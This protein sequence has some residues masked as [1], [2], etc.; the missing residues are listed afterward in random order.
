MKN[1]TE[2]HTHTYTQSTFVNSEKRRN[3][4][5]KLYN[6]SREKEGVK[7]ARDERIRETYARAK[8][9]IWNRER[10]RVCVWERQKLEWKFNRLPECLTHFLFSP[11]TWK[12]SRQP[13]LFQGRSEYRTF[14]SDV[15]VI[16]AKLFNRCFSFPSSFCSSF[17]ENVAL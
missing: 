14:Q 15:L 16:M 5:T 2:T 17:F 9:T 6:R 3:V 13:N 1:Y 4:W 7:E 11:A 8:E 12:W 10:M